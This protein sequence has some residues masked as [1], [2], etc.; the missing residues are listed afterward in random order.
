MF[1]GP[2]TRTILHLYKGTIEIYGT[3]REIKTKQTSRKKKRKQQHQQ[4]QQQQQ[5][6]QRQNTSRQLLFLDYCYY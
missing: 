1:V 2:R 4:Q 6:Q 3:K 5:R